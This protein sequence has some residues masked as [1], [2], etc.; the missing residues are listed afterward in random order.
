VP[1]LKLRRRNS[2]RA[3]LH[4]RGCASFDEV[5][6]ETRTAAIG[7]EKGES[8]FEQK[9]CEIP[10]FWSQMPQTSWSASTPLHWVRRV[11]RHVKQ[12][13]LAGCGHH[14]QVGREG[15][16]SPRDR[17]ARLPRTTTHTVL[18]QEYTFNSP[19]VQPASPRASRSARAHQQ[20]PRTRWIDPYACQTEGML[21]N[22]QRHRTNLR[23]RS[24]TSSTRG[25]RDGRR[26]PVHFMKSFDAFAGVLKVVA[27]TSRA[28]KMVVLNADHPDVGDHHSK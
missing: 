19:G 16:T 24:A 22:T 25:R 21:F 12:I 20:R 27:T 9:D 18:H 28:A 10:T 8:V 7:N 2:R 14:R 15:G 5:T 13:Y 23:Q 6:W 17:C 11:A 4:P 3:A 1:K 26:S